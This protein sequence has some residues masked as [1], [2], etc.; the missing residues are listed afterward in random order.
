MKKYDKPKFLEEFETEVH[1]GN[2]YGKFQCYYGRIFKTRLSAIKN[3]HTK[4]CGCLQRETSSQ[5]G[6]LNATHGHKRCGEESR[7]HHIWIGMRRRCNNPN[8]EAYKNYGGRGII[9]CDRWNNKINGFKNFLEDMG[10]CPKGYEIDRINNNGGYYKENCRWTTS[11]INNRNRRDNI[12][13]EFN[14]KI[15][16]LSAWADE[17]NII[18]GTLR[19]RLYKLKWSMREALTTPTRNSKNNG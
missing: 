7:T 2:I 18:A 3:G 13:L 14:G 10:E 8:D 5:I 4:S 16:C 12:L 1:N 9:V 19:Y 15:Q 17:Y 6:K 11:K